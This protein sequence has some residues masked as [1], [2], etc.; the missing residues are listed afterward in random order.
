ML[1]PEDTT[2]TPRVGSRSS[3]SIVMY[4]SQQCPGMTTHDTGPTDPRGQSD[5]IDA[6]FEHLETAKNRDR[7]SR[8]DGTSRRSSTGHPS[9][10]RSSTGRSK[11]ER[12]MANRPDPA[13]LASN[14]EPRLEELATLPKVTHRAGKPWTAVEAGL[15]AHG[16]LPIYYRLDGMVSYTGYITELVLRPEDESDVPQVLTDNITEADTYSDYNDKY[17]TTT[18]LVEDGRRL[19]E[20]FCQ[21]ELER[22][23]GGRNVDENYSYQ[24]AYVR[25]RDGDFPD[26]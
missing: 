21:S 1:D 9:S 8:R 7:S 22:L 2:D 24:P 14:H 6:M 20:P 19:D 18:Y 10:G 16:R 11:N 3:A 25:Q 13:V 15:A 17:D 26:F 5:T 4:G 12:L 23:Q